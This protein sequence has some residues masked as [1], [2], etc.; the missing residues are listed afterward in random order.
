MIKYTLPIAIEDPVWESKLDVDVFFEEY[1]QKISTQKEII[2]LLPSDIEVSIVLTN[3][4]DI[5]ALNREYRHKDKATNVLS[6]PQEEDLSLVKKDKHCVLLG[7]IV[8]SHETIQKEAEE[9]NILFQ[10]HVGHL[11]VHGFLHLIGFTHDLEEAADKMEEL[12]LKILEKSQKGE[13]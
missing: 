5:H 12:E 9:Q 10:D 7:D 4:Q 1:M 8:L 13:R 6:F 11:F 3:D 2:E